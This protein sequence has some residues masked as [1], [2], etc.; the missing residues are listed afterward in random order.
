MLKEWVN[1]R[2]MVAADEIVALFERTI[3]SY[4]R[5][6]SRTR[7]KARLGDPQD[8]QIVLNIEDVRQLTDRQEKYPPQL[9]GGIS[10]FHGEDPQPTL[11]KEEE[12]EECHLRLE[13]ADLTKFPLTVVS[14]KT[15]DHEDKP[16]ESSQLHYN[17]GEENRGVQP[18][19]RR[20]TRHMTT[21][22]G[23]GSQAAPLS[24]GDNT[25][26]HSPENEDWDDAQD[27]LSSHTGCGDL[28]SGHPLLG[29]LH[30]PVGQSTPYPNKQCNQEEMV[31]VLLK[32]DDDTAANDFLLTKPQMLKASEFNVVSRGIL[33]AGIDSAPNSSGGIYTEGDR[34]QIQS[35]NSL[36]TISNN[37]EVASRANQMLSEFG[38]VSPTTFT[39]Q[40]AAPEV[41][42]PHWL[43]GET[44]GNNKAYVY[45]SVPL[46]EE[47]L[48]EPS[49][50]RKQL[51]EGQNESGLT[52]EKT[53]VKIEGAVNKNRK[54][55]QQS[56]E[57]VKCLQNTN[58]KTSGLPSNNGAEHEGDTSSHGI[59]KVCL[60]SSTSQDTTTKSTFPPGSRGK[61]ISTQGK[62]SSK[63]PNC[64]HQDRSGNNKTESLRTRFTRDAANSNKPVS[65]KSCR[66][67]L[68]STNFSG[69]E[70]SSKQFTR[71][72]NSLSGNT[73]LPSSPWADLL[74][75]GLSSSKSGETI[76]KR[77]RLN[78]SGIISGPVKLQMVQKLA[79][80]AKTKTVAKL[81]KSKQTKLKNTDRG[82]KQDASDETGNKCIPQAV[83][84]VPAREA[85]SLRSP[86]S[87]SHA[88][89]S[90]P[91]LSVK[92]PPI[93]P[94]PEPPSVIGDRLLKN[95]CGQ[96]G[97]V[98]SSSAGL[99]SHMNLHTGHR[100]FPC[101]LCRKSFT[102]AG[103][104]KRHGRVHSNGRSHI[105]QQCGK[106]FVYK[107]G[108]TKHVQVVHTKN[109]SFVCQ[110]CN[111]AF[112][113]KLDVDAHVRIHTGEKPFH[114][115]LCEKRFVKK[116]E[117][118]LHLRW[119]NGEKRHWCP[120]CG[121][122]FFDYNNWKRHKYIHTG[123]KPKSC[124]HCPQ[125]F[126]QS[127]HLKKHIRNVHKIQ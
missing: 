96:C 111:K 28:L 19:S 70:Q 8:R 37:M 127:G 113:T 11:F 33:C 22:A 124:P 9:Q 118:N 25:T 43:L 60:R 41:P 6:L 39:E 38:I 77:T 87:Q 51:D 46:P 89:A 57:K 85:T 90:P 100:P 88:D 117:L 67:S 72:S 10:S 120:F 14:V 80:A 79:K 73:G 61:C 104:L 18:P 16:P 107:Y 53:L 112:F 44:Q 2:L 49:L 115:H 81:D 82:S 94:P 65:E 15:E 5:E 78:K 86:R 110:V 23:G 71:Q 42:T 122:G 108:L 76:A 91:G 3:A 26:S 98:L 114:C 97:R 68:G 45:S 7:E 52:T 4:E 123:E 55:R 75:H 54:E 126:T 30:Q 102:D 24:D 63:K 125:H 13:E 109:K 36:A 59:S 116:V 40:L 99:E 62:A 69:D 31:Y 35:V 93:V 34:S 105:C 95:Q 103:G 92:T 48:D 20:S 27:P 58:K 83:W 50:L 29:T 17:S 47:Q 101:T 21:D 106:D 119:H 32:E 121:K 84:T 56:G 12:V 64:P 66:E 74:E 1:E